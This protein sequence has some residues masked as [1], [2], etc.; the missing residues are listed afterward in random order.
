MS[1]AT[2]LRAG[3]AWVTH[4]ELVAA[5]QGMPASDCG[6]RLHVVDATATVAELACDDCSLVIGV[7]TD[8][9]R[10]VPDPWWHR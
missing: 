6:G 5:I 7:R 1:A 8:E 4:Q 9:V 10:P 2:N 3:E